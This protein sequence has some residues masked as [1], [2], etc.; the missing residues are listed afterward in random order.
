MFAKL[1][2]DMRARARAD[3]FSRCWRRRPARAEP[4]WCAAPQFPAP[5]GWSNPDRSTAAATSRNGPGGTYNHLIDAILGELAV[6][7]RVGMRA[8]HWPPYV[9]SFQTWRHLRGPGTAGHPIRCPAADTEATRLMYLRRL[10]TLADSFLASGRL[11]QVPARRE[12]GLRRAPI[13]MMRDI[14]LQL[15]LRQLWNGPSSVRQGGRRRL[16]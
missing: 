11:A 16:S 8:W 14:R 9:G 4:W 1:V 12:L 2:H 3:S 15:C 6:G 7:A 5:D 10:R 13:S